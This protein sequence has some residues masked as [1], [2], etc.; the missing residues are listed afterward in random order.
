MLHT[1]GVQVIPTIRRFR[2]RRT[3]D[4]SCQRAAAMGLLQAGVRTDQGF[5]A[6]G[7]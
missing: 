4:L 1:L 2:G 5:R 7:R 3:F 6:C